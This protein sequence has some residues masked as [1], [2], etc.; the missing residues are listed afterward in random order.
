MCL[1]LTIKH[2]EEPKPL[3]A[4][5]DI[6]CYKVLCVEAVDDY[7]TPAFRTPYQ[8]FSMYLGERYDNDEEID[9]YLIPF[10]PHDC[11][12]ADE[13]A[14]DHWE[15]GAG[16]FHSYE[17]YKDALDAC[18]EYGDGN[19]VVFAIIPKGTEYY[20]GGF[21]DALCYGSKSLIITRNIAWLPDY[22]ENIYKS[23]STIDRDKLLDI[24]KQELAMREKLISEY[25]LPLTEEDWLDTE[26]MLYKPDEP[27]FEF[28]YDK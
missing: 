18:T 12:D 1:N 15:L 16:I 3:I 13:F 6:I 19:C 25:N 7:G 24:W 27:Y 28:D 11:E 4:E 22:K 8:G 20:E 5:T 17:N 9:S 23:T 2:G 10:D 26:K 21:C 14:Y